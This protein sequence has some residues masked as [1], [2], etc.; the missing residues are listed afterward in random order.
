MSSAA[1]ESQLLS[2]R[3]E[4]KAAWAAFTPILHAIDNGEVMVERYPAGSRGP[5]AADAMISKAGFRKNKE[6][7]W[8]NDIRSSLDI[9]NSLDIRR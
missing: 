7:K 3:D 2:C 5:P 1:F 4:L 9:R 6:Y 8:I